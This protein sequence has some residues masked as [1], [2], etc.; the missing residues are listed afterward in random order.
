MRALI[1]EFD[2]VDS[3]CFRKAAETFQELYAD[4]WGLAVTSD[5]T[6]LTAFCPGPSDP[7][8]EARITGW[9]LCWKAIWL[10]KT[11][12]VVEWR[13]AIPNELTEV[14]E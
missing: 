13:E 2:P 6:S 12:L 3:D 8:L 9:F 10:G 1:L 7:I 5:E 4:P 11:G 14:D